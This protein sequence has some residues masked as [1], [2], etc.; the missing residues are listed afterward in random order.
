[1][2]LGRFGA[3]SPK[4]LLP[5]PGDG[6]VRI[7]NDPLDFAPPFAQAWI[8]DIGDS[9]AIR[10]LIVTQPEYLADGGRIDRLPLF[11]LSNSRKLNVPR[12]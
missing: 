5:P 10:R 8:I 4:S 2:R 1:M 6:S 12:F 7:A 3:F 11:D 9:W